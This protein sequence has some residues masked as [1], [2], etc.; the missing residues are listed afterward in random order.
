[1]PTPRTTQRSL[2]PTTESTT[3]EF[4]PWTWWTPNAKTDAEG[5]NQ[6]RKEEQKSTV[7]TKTEQSIQPTSEKTAMST[8]MMKTTDVVYDKSDNDNETTKGIAIVT[9]EQMQVDVVTE[10][11]GDTSVT[12]TA[13]AWG[14]DG[15]GD[16]DTSV[17]ATAQA[18][19]SMKEKYLKLVEHNSQLVDILRTTMEVQSD[20]FRRILKYMFP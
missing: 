8:I 13:H 14:G 17:T 16:G 19:Q 4:S 12:A 11:D 10:K 3:T 9:T 18:N 5:D 15:G 20:L 1:M 7:E 6:K 2:T